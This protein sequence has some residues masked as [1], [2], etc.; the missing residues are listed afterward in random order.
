MFRSI[1]WTSLCR[2]EFVT[3]VHEP[4]STR[5]EVP[6]ARQ[7]SVDDVSTRPSLHGRVIR[8]CLTL[9]RPPET[10]S[11]AHFRPHQKGLPARF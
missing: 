5:Q 4:D 7:S 9:G 8:K 6:D 2:P 1:G 10:T 11:F 3:R